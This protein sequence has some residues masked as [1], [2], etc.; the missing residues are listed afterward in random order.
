LS[1]RFELNQ[2]NAQALDS[3]NRLILPAKTADFDLRR[4][5]IG[6]TRLR[7]LVHKTKPWVQASVL[8]YDAALRERILQY[9]FTWPLQR[10]LAREGLFFL[11]SAMLWR[12]K[13]HVLIC[14]PSHCGK[15]TLSTVLSGFGFVPLSDDDCFVRLV[16]ES[17][18]ILPFCTKAGVNEKLLPGHPEWSQHILKRYRHYGRPNTTVLY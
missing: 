5:I 16:D 10:L 1:I 18:E 13:K 15:S 11:H 12:G 3:R 6:A 17:V 7:V 2:V 9:I 14:G 8:N 4:K